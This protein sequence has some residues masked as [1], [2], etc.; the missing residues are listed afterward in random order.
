MSSSYSQTVELLRAARGGNHAALE[1]IATKYHDRLLNRIRLMMGPEARRCAESGDFLQTVFLDLCTHAPVERLDDE[2]GLLGFMTAIARNNI[3]SA[4]RKRRERALASFS[5]SMC[6]PPVD[7][8]TPSADAHH[9]ETV[10]LLITAIERLNADHRTVIE[11]RDLEQLPF[12][13]IAERMG[14]SEAA[15]QMLHARALLKLGG[16]LK[17]GR[18]R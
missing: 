18:P 15:V 11:L 13:E 9:A 1:R 10:R 12:R 2:E 3:T 14:K 16:M 17:A 5:A 7:G 6:G 4:L 8:R